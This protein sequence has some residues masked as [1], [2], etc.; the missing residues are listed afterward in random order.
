MSKTKRDKD[1]EHSARQY[2]YLKHKIEDEEGSMKKRNEQKRLEEVQ[3]I[4]NLTSYEQKLIRGQSNA[5]MR[6]RETSSR[7]SRT[8]SHLEEAR[9]LSQS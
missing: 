5:Q 7:A 2:E 1:R 3:V 8:S 9:R 4:S 6:L